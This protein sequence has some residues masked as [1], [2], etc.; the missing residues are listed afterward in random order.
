MKYF[1][2]NYLKYNRLS[3]LLQIKFK[4]ASTSPFA[5][6]YFPKFGFLLRALRKW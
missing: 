4:V 2:D 6:F 3:R 5:E 1:S